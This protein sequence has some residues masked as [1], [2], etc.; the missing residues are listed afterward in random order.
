MRKIKR[1]TMY[2]LAKGRRFANTPKG[3]RVITQVLTSMTT[4]ALVM[5]VLLV[6]G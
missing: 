1:L 3:E 2:T 6:I 5:G 4:L